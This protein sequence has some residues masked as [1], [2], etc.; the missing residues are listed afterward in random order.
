MSNDNILLADYDTY[1][2]E[3]GQTANLMRLRL[4][5]TSCAHFSCF[6]FQAHFCFIGFVFFLSLA[7]VTRFVSDARLVHFTNCAIIFR[8]KL[9]A[10]LFQ[11]CATEISVAQCKLFSL[12]SISA[13][14]LG[15]SPHEAM[16]THQKIACK[17][18]FTSRRTG[19]GMPCSDLLCALWVFAF[20]VTIPLQ[21]TAFVSTSG[22]S[23]L[24]EW[25]NWN[26]NKSCDR[27]TINLG[28]VS[29]FPSTYK[30]VVQEK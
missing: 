7:P 23:A 1:T 21:P 12:A 10:R 18:L 11:N 26:R 17:S 13:V 6:L 15:K 9:D 14:L 19:L 29:R 3:I 16:L 22:L 4:A 2:L 25:Q 28:P 27:N 5:S 30:E 8:T 24:H 20:S